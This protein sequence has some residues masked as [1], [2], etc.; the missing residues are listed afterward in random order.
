M[1]YYRRKLLLAILEVF[2]GILSSKMLQK[3]LFLATRGQDVKV[4]DFVPFKYGCF[5]FQA[6]QDLE[7]LVKLGYLINTT[8][9]GNDGYSLIKKESMLSELDMFGRQKVVQLRNDFVNYSQNELIR[10]V[11]LKAP[12]YAINSVIAKDLLSEEELSRVVA[13]RRH[14]E[15]QQLFTIGYEGISLEA[16]IVQ[17]IL[18]DVK[19][20]CDVRKNAYSRKFG[21]SK[22][23]LNRACVGVGIKYIHI[24][25]LGIDS[26]KRQELNTQADYNALFDDYESTS[27]KENWNYLNII[28]NLLHQENRVALTCFE[29][30]PLMC[31]RSRVAKAVLSLTE[32]DISL[33]NI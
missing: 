31:H 22:A 4:Y 29:K 25:E 23:I 20:L 10:Y 32:E 7:T 3:Y 8:V 15:E 11:Y 24:P 2:G 26:E 13:Q 19:V 16:Y 27:L 21:F 33:T 5:S 14:I 30:N 28:V 17:L 6:E 9:D 12:F 18:K 1:L